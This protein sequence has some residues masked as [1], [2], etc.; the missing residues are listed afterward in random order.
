RSQGRLEIPID[1][2]LVIA[3]DAVDRG[4]L[5]D[6]TVLSVVITPGASGEPELI[7]VTLGL[8]VDLVLAPAV[9]GA[10]R[11]VHLERTGHVRILSGP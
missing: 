9:P 4:P 2:A 11:T 5:P 8:D 1:R 3:A 7:D 6:A 10:P